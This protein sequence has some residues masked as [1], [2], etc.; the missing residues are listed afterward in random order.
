MLHGFGRADALLV[1]LRDV[2]A[3]GTGAVADHLGVDPRAAGHGEFQLLEDED[4]RPFA[5]HEAVPVGVERAAG[6][7][8]VVVALRQGAHRREGAD[9]HGRDGGLGA[10]GDHHVGVVVLDGLEGLA[11]G[12]GGAG[13]GGRHGG[14][15]P[16]KPV[17]DGK[18]PA[19]RIDHQLGDGEGGDLVGA[20]L[21]EAAVLGFD[22][23]QAADAG[24]ENRLRNGIDRAWRTPARRP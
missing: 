5:E 12:I 1:G 11:D 15:R 2:P 19:G 21:H 23:L 18:L 7:G 8:R 17:L 24:A 13:A 20:F 6:T 10:A 4:S 14:V 3:V 22:L 9:A 16:A